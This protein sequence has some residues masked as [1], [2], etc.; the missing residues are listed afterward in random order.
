MIGDTRL[1]VRFWAKVT[2]DASGCWLWTAAQNGRGYGVYR[3][4]G[5]QWLAH[6]A[7]YA[8][9]VAPLTAGRTVDHL[10]RRTLCCNPLHL[11]EVPQLENIMRGNSTAAQLRRRG[12]CLAGHPRNEQNTRVGSR[13]WLECRPCDLARYHARSARE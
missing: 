2:A 6:R 8:A 12:T 11:E 3:H 9:L 5:K 13:G 4:E 7:A 10:C 1:P